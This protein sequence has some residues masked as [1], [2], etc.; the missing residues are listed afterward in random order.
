MRDTASGL[1]VKLDSYGNYTVLV[2]GDEWLR[3][4]PTSFTVNSRHY[5]TED[6]SLQLLK[7]SADNGT[8]VLGPWKAQ[9]FY[10]Q[11]NDVQV[12][13]KVSV[14][15]YIH[16]SCVIFSQVM[17]TMQKHVFKSQY[18]YINRSIIQIPL[19]TYQFECL[20]KCYK[21]LG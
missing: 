14:K 11:P 8:D 5:S 3:S 16:E 20:K 2:G 13:V 7:K 21:T 9:N 12:T 18:L 17:A 10:Y 15:F 4:A 19:L 6:G 1:E